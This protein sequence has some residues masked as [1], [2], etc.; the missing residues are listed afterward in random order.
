MALPHA[1]PLDVISVR[2]LGPELAGAVSTSLLKTDR[3]Q[4]LH[5][6]LPARHDQPPH[7]VADECTIHCLEGDVEVV[8]PSGNRRLG[9]GQLVVLPGGQQHSLS[10]RADSAVL[11]TL[12]LRNGDAGDGGGAGAQTLQAR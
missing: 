7:H 11:M 6:V 2:P 12:L 9:P 1:Q 8:M 4:L 10:A 3:I 5:L